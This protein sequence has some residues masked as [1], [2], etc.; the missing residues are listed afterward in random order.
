MWSRPISRWRSGEVLI[1][2]RSIQ[3]VFG[4]PRLR[5]S[6]W[7]YRIQ[8]RLDFS[9]EI[10]RR[11][12]GNGN[13]RAGRELTLIVYSWC[14]GTPDGF[15][16]VHVD[17]D[18][19]LEAVILYNRLYCSFRS[20]LDSLRC[21]SEVCLVGFDAS[22]S[23]GAGF[24]SAG[25]FISRFGVNRICADALNQLCPWIIGVTLRAGRGLCMCVCV[26][27]CTFLWSPTP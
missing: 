13:L 3:K 6:V 12:G 10:R 2:C 17:V 19:W 7:E 20:D 9:L 18:W 5:S 22:E 4:H 23:V 11:T 26:S 15:L 25:E 24:G 1:Q 16:C 14:V 8:V 21:C 27:T